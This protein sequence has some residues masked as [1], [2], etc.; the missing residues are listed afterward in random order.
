MSHCVR[1]D[2]AVK[3][4]QRV[5]TGVHLAL[6]SRMITA[7]RVPAMLRTRTWQN[8]MKRVSAA[9]SIQC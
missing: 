4:Q 5:R 1:R 7:D 8:R 6:L 2:S 9:S 3:L